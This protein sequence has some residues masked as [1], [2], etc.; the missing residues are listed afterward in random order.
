M[1]CSGYAGLFLGNSLVYLDIG[2]QGEVRL[3]LG[4]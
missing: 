3:D 1:F 2:I 4:G